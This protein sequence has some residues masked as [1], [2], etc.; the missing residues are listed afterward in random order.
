MKL[1]IKGKIIDIADDVLSKALEAK[2]ESL[3][4]NSDFILR[5]QDE[6]NSFIEN[7]KKDARKEG[8]EIAVK[9]FREANN[10][11]FEGKTIEALAKALEEKTLTD[12]KI[13]PEEKNKKLT[14]QLT[15]KENAL[16]SALSKISE[17]ENKFKTFQSQI[18]IEKTL[19]SFIPENTIL[20]KE[21]M[22]TLL[23]TKMN[24][25]EDENGNIIVLDGSGNIVKNPTTADAMPV[26]DLIQ[27]FFKTN[28]NYI[29]GTPGGNGGSDSKG[30]SGKI[31]VNQF[32]ES[33]KEKGIPFNSEAYTK[34][35]QKAVESNLIDLDA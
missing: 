14:Q 19:D 2:Q 26:K 15:E 35:L 32:T 34:E 30:G 25:S 6:E 13:E 12:A 3:E 10:L 18:K 8:L 9:R 16:Q 33:M 29:S 1:N 7:H 21:D 4:V 27:D 20:P 5:T 23:K 28:Q 22:K 11:S 24:F 17:A 31:S